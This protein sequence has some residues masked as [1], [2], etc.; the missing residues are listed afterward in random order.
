MFQAVS[1][2]ASLEPRIGNVGLHP[3]RA[4]KCLIVRGGMRHFFQAVN[5][6]FSFITSDT[7]SALMQIIPHHDNG[8]SCFLQ[9]LSGE[10]SRKCGMADSMSTYTTGGIWWILQWTPS[11]LQLSP[12]KLLP[13]SRYSN[14][15]EGICHLLVRTVVNRVETVKIKITD[16]RE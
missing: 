4:V 3:H 14:L 13:T 5:L 9:V 6:S 1:S 16:Q 7:H 10:K 2:C 12:L 15:G 8:L 11:I